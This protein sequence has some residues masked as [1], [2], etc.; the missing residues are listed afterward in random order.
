MQKKQSKFKARENSTQPPIRNMME[1]LCGRLNAAQM[2]VPFQQQVHALEQHPCNRVQQMHEI[3]H[4]RF[5][6]PLA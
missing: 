4:S 5:V 3:W 2:P 6:L 1:T